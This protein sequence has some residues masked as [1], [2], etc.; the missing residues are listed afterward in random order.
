MSYI[1]KM[2]SLLFKYYSEFEKSDCRTL[3]RAW[4]PFKSRPLCHPC[5]CAHEAPPPHALRN[6][7]TTTLVP[8][9]FCCWYFRDHSS[10]TAA[11]TTGACYFQGEQWLQMSLA[12]RNSIWFPNAPGRTQHALY[13][14]FGPGR[15]TP[16][17][18]GSSAVEVFDVKFHGH[19]HGSQTH[20]LCPGTQRQQ[21]AACLATKLVSNMLCLNSGLLIEMALNG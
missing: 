6:R 8:W 7:L 10:I 12:C 5:V 16:W 21:C 3:S 14:L 19:S 2:R 13:I 20:E 1:M 15:A 4:S 9:G 17:H 18:P 11:L